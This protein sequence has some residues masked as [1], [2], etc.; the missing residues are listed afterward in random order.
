MTFR[1]CLKAKIVQMVPKATFFRFCF[2]FARVV[3]LNFQCLHKLGISTFE[4]QA[5]MK[6]PSSMVHTWQHTCSTHNIHTWVIYE[7]YMVDILNMYG[8]YMVTI[9]VPYITHTCFKFLYSVFTIHVP[10]NPYLGCFIITQ[11]LKS[12]VFPP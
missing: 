5:P 3:N 1:L 10:Y 9:H 11:R 7:T 12:R 8:P 2:V 6:W 4:Y